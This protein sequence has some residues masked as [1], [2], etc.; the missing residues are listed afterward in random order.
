[1]DIA[2]VDPPAQIDLHRL[3]CAVAALVDC[4]SHGGL[5]DTIGL[6]RTDIA[7]RF[8]AETSA[9]LQGSLRRAVDRL[10]SPAEDAGGARTLNAIAE[11]AAL[12]HVDKD[13]AAGL[14]AALL[15]ALPPARQGLLFDPDGHAQP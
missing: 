13:A 1:V 14:A 11:L 12:T 15:P 9:L 4:V 6:R 8:L 2:S 7:V 10:L 3:R 5:V